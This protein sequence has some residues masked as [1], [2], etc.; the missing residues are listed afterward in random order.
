MRL[1]DLRR[2][3]STPTTKPPPNQTTRTPMLNAIGGNP[4]GRWFIGIP[5]A[6]A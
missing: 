2:L 4:N 3:I 5:P 6:S 1:Y